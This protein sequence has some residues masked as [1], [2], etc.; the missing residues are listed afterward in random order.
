[1][2][3]VAVEPNPVSEFLTDKAVQYLKIYNADIEWLDYIGELYALLLKKT[4]NETEAK[5][6]VKQ[7]ISFTILAP[8]EDSSI[9]KEPYHRLLFGCSS[10]AKFGEKDWEFELRK[11]WE[12]DAKIET[13]R[14]QL[15]SMGIIYPVEYVPMTR[16]A[17]N[18][19]MERVEDNASREVTKT[20]MQNLVFAY[21]GATICNIFLKP[22]YQ[23]KI[24]KIPNWRTGYFFERLIY[25]VYKPE[26][27]L[28]I[29]EHEL[30]KVD[31][32]L[33]KKI[34]INN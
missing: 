4:R 8:L 13:H 7:H 33:V 18:W 6:R 32:K 29:K 22:E 23:T 3:E 30:N 21:G 9:I 1:L 15:L 16:Q 20:K 10:F 28:R 5:Q 19:L 24:N 25:E 2:N 34:R 11:I 17:L 31:S 14:N 27:M 26:Q 12:H